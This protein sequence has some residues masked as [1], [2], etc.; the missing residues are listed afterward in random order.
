MN[1]FMIAFLLHFRFSI[2]TFLDPGLKQRVAVPKTVSCIELDQ[3]GILELS[4]YFLKKFPSKAVPLK[5]PQILSGRSLSRNPGALTPERWLAWKT[6]LRNGGWK[7][8]FSSYHTS[9]EQRED[10]PLIQPFAIPEKEKVPYVGYSLHHRN[11]IG[12]A[13]VT[14]SKQKI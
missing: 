2:R 4:I 9:Q 13:L 3:D 5:F 8:G 12:L 1:T 14:I 10:M 6:K 11:P 7:A